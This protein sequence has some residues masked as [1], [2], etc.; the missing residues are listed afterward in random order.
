MPHCP[1]GIPSAPSDPFL[2]ARTCIFPNPQRKALK[3]NRSACS[4]HGRMEQRGFCC[5][6]WRERAHINLTF[7]GSWQGQYILKKTAFHLVFYVYIILNCPKP[8][9]NRVKAN[10]KETQAQSH[11]YDKCNDFH[12]LFLSIPCPHMCKVCAQLSP[13]LPLLW[14]ALHCDGDISPRW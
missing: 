14:E 8:H 10:E 5:W 7:I 3:N 12:V 4:F 13:K 1:D 9:Q 2:L 6:W 11:H